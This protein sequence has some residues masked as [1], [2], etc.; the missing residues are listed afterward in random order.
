MIRNCV[1]GSPDWHFGRGW[2]GLGAA[3]LPSPSLRGPVR[4]VRRRRS[5][6]GGVVEGGPEATDGY[7]ERDRSEL[8]DRLARELEVAGVRERGKDR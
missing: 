5:A 6:G 8:G 7:G 2:R 1:C 4:A 3:F